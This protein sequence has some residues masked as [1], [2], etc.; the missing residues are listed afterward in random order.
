MPRV[1][2]V[3][4]QAQQRGA[5]VDADSR[6]VGGASHFDALLDDSDRTAA[7]MALAAQLTSEDR[8]K[9]ARAV[10]LLLYAR[11]DELAHAALRS[12]TDLDDMIATLERRL[13]ARGRAG[14]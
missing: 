12:V 3:T 10:E 14:Q 4:L 8:A 7:L 5:V 11:G 13:E 6:A 2:A 9:C 1:G